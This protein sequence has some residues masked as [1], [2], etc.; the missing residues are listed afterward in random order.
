VE[1]KSMYIS[2]IKDLH[3]LVEIGA[4]TDTDFQ[5]QKKSI[6]ELMDKL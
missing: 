4:I 2:Q 3:S 1:L 5:K 6:L